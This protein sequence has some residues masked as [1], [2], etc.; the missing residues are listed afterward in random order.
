MFKFLERVNIT[1]RFESF[2]GEEGKSVKLNCEAKGKPQPVVQWYKDIQ[3]LS[4]NKHTLTL[5][6]IK[7]AI[8]L[9]T[10]YYILKINPRNMS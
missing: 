7:I 4:G 6:L 5:H 10:Y 2:E 8:S 3:V 9:T 1:N